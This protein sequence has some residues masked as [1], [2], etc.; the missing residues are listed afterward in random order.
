MLRW[1]SVVHYEPPLVRQ[2]STGDISYRFPVLVATEPQVTD[3]KVCVRF[4]SLS[5]RVDRAGRLVWRYLDENNYY[6][7]LLGNTVLTLAF[8]V[9]SIPRSAIL[10]PALATEATQR[11]SD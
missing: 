8:V 1:P 7:V 9:G 3:G 11:A 2:A 6:G 4:K 10:R 5:G